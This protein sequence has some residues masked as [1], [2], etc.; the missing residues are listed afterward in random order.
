[1][2]PFEALYRRHCRSPIR[3]FELDKT[4][5]LGPDLVQESMNKVQL[6]QERLLVAQS[7]QKVYVGHQRRYL[8]FS[9]GDHVFLI[10]SP[11]KRMM[12]FGKRGKLNP[13]YI[14]SFKI[15]DRVGA[16]AYK[17]A[18]PLDLSMI[19]PIFHVSMLWKYVSDPS[20]IFAP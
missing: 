6:I 11:M 17:L 18:L 2:A 13:H 20:H 1:M 14:R 7:R 15:L 9:V 4:K 8:E 12:S 10:I 5:L 3:W 19:H 16:I